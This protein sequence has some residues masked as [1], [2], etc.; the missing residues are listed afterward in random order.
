MANPPPVNSFSRKVY[1]KF[2]DI[3]LDGDKRLFFI[4]LLYG[5]IMVVNI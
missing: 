5:M 4:L 3:Y 2:K 1:E